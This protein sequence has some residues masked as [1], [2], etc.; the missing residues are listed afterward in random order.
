MRLPS[1]LALVAVLLVAVVG[2]PN[3]DE[4]SSIS[5]KVTVAG[6]GPLT[7]GGIQFVSVEYPNRVGSAVIS[8]DGTYTVVDAPL[9]ECKVVIDTTMFDPNALK[10]KEGLGTVG[11][12]PGVPPGGN[13]G[14]TGAGG[15]GPGSKTV[16]GVKGPP[17]KKEPEKPKGIDLSPE[18]GTSTKNTT[19]LKFVKIEDGLNKA[20]S[21]PLRATIERGQNTKDFEVKEAPAEKK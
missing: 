12:G 19:P 18:F 20:E 15:P 4:R 16:P 17:P 10:G 7:G 2:C 8:G 13:P 9:G 1:H 14:K 11:S 21:T 3:K 5:G 6:K